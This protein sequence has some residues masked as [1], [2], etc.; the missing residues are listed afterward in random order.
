MEK[1]TKVAPSVPIFQM[2]YREAQVWPEIPGPHESGGLAG[3]GR[4]QGSHPGGF[5]PQWQAAPSLDLENLDLDGLP[6]P[7]SC[8]LLYSISVFFV[9]CPTPGCTPYPSLF[10]KLL[11][12]PQ[13]PAA[14]PL[15]FTQAFLILQEEP[16]LPS[17][18]WLH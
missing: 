12:I 4:A 2:G 1:A 9:F 7:Q 3:P 15:F 8:F 18:L 5:G 17:G 10:G 13:S 11:F 14:I 6:P 16:P